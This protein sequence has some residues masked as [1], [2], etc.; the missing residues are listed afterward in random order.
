MVFK[1]FFIYLMYINT[2]IKIM[3]FNLKLATIEKLS[4]GVKK[5]HFILKLKT[6]N[7]SFTFAISSTGT[8]LGI[9]GYY[10]MRELVLLMDWLKEKNTEYKGEASL[11]NNVMIMMYAKQLIKADKFIDDAKALP[12]EHLQDFN[13]ISY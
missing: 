4:S 13:F 2:K 6:T 8:S 3:K 5:A 11:N 1:I 9:E 7:D 10:V 12:L